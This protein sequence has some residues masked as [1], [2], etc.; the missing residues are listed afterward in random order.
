MG[1]KMKIGYLI[2]EFP[3]QTHNFFWRERNALGEYGI[4]TK[5]I[6]TKRPPKGIVS[7]S[8][9]DEA[10]SETAY[11]YPLAH[12]DIIPIIS[13][14][15]KS[16]PSALLRCLRRI[17]TNTELPVIGRLRL[18]LFIPFAAKLA[19]ICKSNNCEHVHVHS[20]AD[21]ANIA[22]LANALSGASYSLT[23]HN[24][25]NVFGGNQKNKWRYAKFAVVI[26]NKLYNDVNEHLAGFLPSHVE[27]APMGVD[28][29][30][31]CRSLPYVPYDGHETLQ[32]LSCGRLNPAKGYIYLIAAI[33]QLVDAGLN[34]KLNI[35]GE[36]DLGGVG[37]RNIIER[38][39]K[40]LDLRSVVN[41][42]G[43]V[44]EEQVKNYLNE[45]HYFILAS[46]EE[47]LGVVLM[48]AM[49]MGVPVI[50]T[51]S[52]GVPELVSNRVDGILVEPANS[53]ALAK[54]VL[55]LVNDQDLTLKLSN[56]SRRKVL[57]NF[58][59]RRSAE[60]I[61]SLLRA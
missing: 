55:E 16:G 15:L 10:I 36:D 12:S 25:L 26:T 54:A 22:M 52:G 51:K 56:S 20:C 7:T 43:A 14:I 2:P 13:L 38:E 24:P 39:I 29:V 17:F 47:P 42:L 28:T 37:Y 34:I 5:I 23:L 30:K 53:D 8:W 19:L 31:F 48:E 60:V 33:R 4:E 18:T 6:S 44:S 9:A 49:S 27:V 1:S 3:G 46:L 61:A 40:K 41:L 21:S 35:A 57:Q 11:L 45:A 59:F 50:A 58:T 32:I